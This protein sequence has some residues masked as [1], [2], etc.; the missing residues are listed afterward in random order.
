MYRTLEP[1]QPEVPLTTADADDGPL[2]SRP[3]GLSHSSAEQV[4]WLGGKAE[5]ADLRRMAG[6]SLTI[7]APPFIS[8]T[9]HLPFGDIANSAPPLAEPGR[10][11]TDPVDKAA[12]FSTVIEKP[13]RA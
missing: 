11:M 3:P 6:Q 5:P 10:L 13:E 7:A 8:A 12:M 4:R 1:G 9:S 2:G